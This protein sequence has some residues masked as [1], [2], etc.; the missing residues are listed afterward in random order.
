[1]ET[2]NLP[3][4]TLGGIVLIYGILTT[5]WGGER[6][7]KRFYTYDDYRKYDLRL[8]KLVQIISS[9]ILGL[10]IICIGFWKNRYV[11]LLVGV[12]VVVVRFILFY[13][14]CK[15]RTPPQDDDC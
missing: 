2:I 3:L 4:I 13:T 9:V 8:T 1:M 15:K 5:I 14:L 6:F 7:M 10:C 11:L 12:I